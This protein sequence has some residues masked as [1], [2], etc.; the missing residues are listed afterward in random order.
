MGQ[1]QRTLP[2]VPATRALPHKTT[3][4][5]TRRRARIDDK[6]LCLSATQ[7]AHTH[8]FRVATRRITVG[9]TCRR[10]KQDST[11]YQP[12]NLRK[13]PPHTYA[14]GGQVQTMLGGKLAGFHG[15]LNQM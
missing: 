3:H 7:N 10:D 15:K 4:P 14:E 2:R 13:S 1:S 5:P 8:K 11:A 12:P 6:T 9:F